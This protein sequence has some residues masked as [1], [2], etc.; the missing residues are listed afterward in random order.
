MQAAF[1]YAT[2]IHRVLAVGYVWRREPLEIC[3]HTCNRLNRR[4]CITASLVLSRDREDPHPAR[5]AST[6]A[7]QALPAQVMLCGRRLCGSSANWR[8]NRNTKYSHTYHERW[9]LLPQPEASPSSIVG[10]R[11]YLDYMAWSLL[12]DYVSELCTV[13]SCA[14]AAAR[15]SLALRTRPSLCCFLGSPDLNLEW[16]CETS[17]FRL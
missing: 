16:R 12:A 1:R 15:T 9:D 11:R 5:M 8:H 10:C 14:M 7:R 2:T 17:V 4:A 6:P 13:I 3:A